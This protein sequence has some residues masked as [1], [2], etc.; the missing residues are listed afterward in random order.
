[1]LGNFSHRQYLTVIDICDWMKFITKLLNLVKTIAKKIKD[2]SISVFYIFMSESKKCNLNHEPQVFFLRSMKM[3]WMNWAEDW[4]NRKN[5]RDKR[6]SLPCNLIWID[7][8]LVFR[9]FCKRFRYCEHGKWQMSCMRLS[10]VWKNW[11][12]ARGSYVRGVN[13]PD[14]LHFNIVFLAFFRLFILLACIL[15]WIKDRN[16]YCY[17]IISWEAWSILII[18]K[19]VLWTHWYKYI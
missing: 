15:S 18:K 6:E 2:F 19:S 3:F 10:F 8:A 13:K 7:Q 14:A 1:M 9:V 4:Y 12:F 17:Q 11:M 16:L 5:E